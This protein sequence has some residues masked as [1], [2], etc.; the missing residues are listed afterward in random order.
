MAV[1]MGSVESYSANRNEWSTTAYRDGIQRRLQL[2][3]T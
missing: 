1:V 3:L 2:P